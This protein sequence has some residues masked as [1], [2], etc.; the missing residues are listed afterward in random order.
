MKPSRS[1]RD[2]TFSRAHLTWMG[3][4]DDRLAWQMLP[5]GRRRLAAA[6]RLPG[7]RGITAR[8]PGFAYL[9]ARTL[10]FDAFVRDALDNGIRQIV[11][12]AA[13]YDTRAWRLRR[14]GVTFFEVDRQATQD[15]KRTRAPD[16]GPVYVSA[17][18]ADPQLPHKL[19]DAG[20]QPRQPTAFAVEGLIIYLTK[21]DVTNLLVRLSELG[22]PGSRLAASF[23]SGFRE[24]PMTRALVSGYR[25]WFGEPLR[26]RLPAEDAESFLSSSSWT[27]E[28][29]LDRSGLERRHL[30]TTKLAGTLRT[31]SFVVTASNRSTP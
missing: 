1:A 8:D 26:F 14:P 30:A 10:F 19:L 29:L 9:A 3:V 23:E 6:W 7:I 12:L 11:I 27:M 18:V 31:S 20:Y 21:G 13:G 24:R 5:T 22:A 15:D 2:V 16:D 25:R 17:D 28:S 4:V